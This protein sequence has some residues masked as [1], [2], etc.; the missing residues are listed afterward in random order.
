MKER[1]MNSTDRKEPKRYTFCAVA[2]QKYKTILFFVCR[3]KKRRK[4]ERKRERK[5]EEKESLEKD[6]NNIYILIVHYKC[7]CVS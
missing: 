7:D 5:K 4:N 1:S 3:T 6:L 2:E